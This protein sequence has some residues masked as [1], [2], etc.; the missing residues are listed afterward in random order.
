MR[1][2]TITWCF[3]V[4]KTSVIYS[5]HN[6]LSSICYF[7]L[8]ALGL[9]FLKEVFRNCKL[10]SLFMHCVAF[11]KTARFASISTYKKLSFPCESLLSMNS[12]QCYY[13]YTGQYL[14]KCKWRKTCWSCMKQL[15]IVLVSADGGGRNNY[16]LILA[17]SCLLGH[18]GDGAVLS[19]LVVVSAHLM[20]VSLIFTLIFSSGLASTNSLGKKSVALLQLNALLWSPATR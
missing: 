2:I 18:P 7:M 20:K 8:G 14:N 17:N 1:K 12:S 5:R 16:Q 4:R 11:R 19:L 10:Y 15:L 6:F 3:W 13:S 9:H